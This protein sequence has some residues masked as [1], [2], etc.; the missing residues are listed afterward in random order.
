MRAEIEKSSSSA[1]VSFYDLAVL[2]R[3]LGETDKSFVFLSR[4]FEEHSSFVPFLN[5]DPRLDDAR[6]DR[7]FQDLVERMNFPAHASAFRRPQ[8]I[9]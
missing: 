9:G 4:A 8:R 7:R 6:A 2:Y 1:Y 5:V 3:A